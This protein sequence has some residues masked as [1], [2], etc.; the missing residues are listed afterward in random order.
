[1][2][3]AKKLRF[4]DH[5]GNG[6]C[7]LERRTFSACWTLFSTIKSCGKV[8]WSKA[9]RHCFVGCSHYGKSQQCSDV[10]AEFGWHGDTWLVW[11]ARVLGRARHKA[12]RD[13]KRDQLAE[14][15]R[16]AGFVL[17]LVLK[18]AT[19]PTFPTILS[20]SLSL[21]LSLSLLLSMYPFSLAIFSSNLY[22]KSP[23][24]ALNLSP[25]HCLNW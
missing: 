1:M 21:S 3:F 25:S 12:A 14:H 2:V 19:F 23:L 13:V 4:V 16:A 18:K 9:W 24:K 10:W 8:L 22:S 15:V 7:M 20:W 17:H 11:E 5:G 6:K